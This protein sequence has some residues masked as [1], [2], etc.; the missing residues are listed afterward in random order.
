MMKALRDVIQVVRPG[1]GAAS[2]QA[3]EQIFDVIGMA[4]LLPAQEPPPGGEQ[5]CPRLW[6]QVR[7]PGQVEIPPFPWNR[8]LRPLCL[9]N[10]I[11]KTSPLRLSVCLQCVLQPLQDE[12]LFRGV[13]GRRA[14]WQ[15]S[16]RREGD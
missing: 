13:L 8:L 16:L 3:V 4:L 2:S 14:Q 1:L 10:L 15:P 7:A 5:R 9:N 12:R 11:G 6:A